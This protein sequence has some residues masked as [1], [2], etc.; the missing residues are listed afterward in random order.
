[1]TAGAK[2]T[3]TAQRLKLILSI[4]FFLAVAVIVT[5]IVDRRPALQPI[6]AIRAESRILCRRPALT[7]L[8]YKVGSECVKH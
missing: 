1:M 8:K 7:R 3:A 2:S 6:L 5:I 4:P